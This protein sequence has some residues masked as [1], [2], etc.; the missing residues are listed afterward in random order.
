LYV[1][2]LFLEKLKNKGIGRSLQNCHSFLCNSQKTY[3]QKPT[4]LNFLL[5][6]LLILLVFLRL[7]LKTPSTWLKAK[8]RKAGCLLYM[9]LVWVPS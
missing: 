5:L 3:W 6:I 2:E 1:G 8:G 4:V 7:K 9:P